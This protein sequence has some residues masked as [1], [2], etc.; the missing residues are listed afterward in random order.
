MRLNLAALVVDHLFSFLKPIF[1]KWVNDSYSTF[2]KGA[3]HGDDWGSNWTIDLNKGMNS[4][5]IDITNPYFALFYIM[6]L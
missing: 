6:K 1:Q 4:T 2:I 5:P 3:D